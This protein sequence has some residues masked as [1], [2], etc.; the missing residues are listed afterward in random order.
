MPLHRRQLILAVALFAVCGLLVGAALAAARWRADNSVWRSRALAAETEQAETQASLASASKELAALTKESKELRERVDEIANEKAGVEDDVAM[1]KVERDS[2]ERLAAR[3][4]DTI[5]LW[6]ECVK[7][8]QQWAQVLADKSRYN[9][10]DVK[11]YY[12]DLE[13]VCRDAKQAD[14]ALQS[15]L[16]Q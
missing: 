7:G 8:H 2:Y 12:S 13:A 5:D 9:A 4:A 15:Q 16:S 3:F 1:A 11:R 14:D 6:R 10:A